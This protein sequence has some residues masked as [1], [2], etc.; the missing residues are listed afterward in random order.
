MKKGLFSLI[1]TFITLAFFAFNFLYF[2]NGV[3]LPL[4]ISIF[5]SIIALGIITFALSTYS[6]TKWYN[7]PI[8]NIVGL[9]TI[10]I[11]TIFTKVDISLSILAFSIG[12]GLYLLPYFLKH[13][14]QFIAV[15]ISVSLVMISVWFI[16]ASS[17]IFIDDKLIRSIYVLFTTLL[18][19]ITAKGISNFIYKK[20]VKNLLMFIGVIILFISHAFILV[21]SF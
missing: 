4:K 10:M 7:P 5:M 13:K 14:G 9:F 1:N 18:S 2:E 3:A 6:K 12:S 20:S 21:L 19:L 15:V 8:S 11:L 17:H 16:Q